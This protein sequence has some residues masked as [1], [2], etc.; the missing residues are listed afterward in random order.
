M[1]DKGVNEMRRKKH[2]K[3]KKQELFEE[4]EKQDLAEQETKQLNEEIEDPEFRS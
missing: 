1:I 2:K 3:K 4:I